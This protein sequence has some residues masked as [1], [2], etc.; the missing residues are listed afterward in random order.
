MYEALTNLSSVNTKARSWVDGAGSFN[1]LT[2]K[3]DGMS[4]KKAFSGLEKIDNGLQRF[5]TYKTMKRVA[6]IEKQDI[7]L[8]IPV[9]T[10]K[11]IVRTYSSVYETYSKRYDQIQDKLRQAMEDSGLVS[12]KLM[13]KIKELNKD[14]FP[15]QKIY[16][17]EFKGNKKVASG[18]RLQEMK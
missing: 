10:A 6:E 13:T 7:D 1:M 15:M 9:D 16:S 8:N 4:L 17:A 2:D 18:F 3:I 11:K 14:F 5:S 12:Q